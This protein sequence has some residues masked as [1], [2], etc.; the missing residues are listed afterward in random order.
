MEV[1][2][3]QKPY[4]DIDNFDDDYNVSSELG[5]LATEQLNK[6]EIEELDF[7]ATKTLIEE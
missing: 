6:Q 7:N 4:I 5:Y 3:T 2:I 1:S